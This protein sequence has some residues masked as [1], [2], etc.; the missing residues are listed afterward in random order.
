LYILVNKLFFYAFTTKLNLLT[1]LII[2]LSSDIYIHIP[3]CSIF[4]LFS[5]SLSLFLQD[6]KKKHKFFT[7]AVWLEYIFLKNAHIKNTN[8]EN[9]LYHPIFGW[10]RRRRKLT[11]NFG[12]IKIGS[13]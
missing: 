13:Q 4:S 2:R 6:R 11:F 10:G 9:T 12:V 3:L 1:Q 8:E 5:L 7:V